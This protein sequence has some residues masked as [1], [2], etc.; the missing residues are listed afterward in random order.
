MFARAA[1]ILLALF[2]AVP[3]WSAG[4]E[5]EFLGA[6]TAELENP[7]DLKL[8]SDGKFLF[9]SDVGNNRIAVLNP[10]TLEF[11]SAF[12]ADHQSGTHDIDFDAQGRAYV[13]DTH[14]NRVTESGLSTLVASKC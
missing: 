6:S 1:A 10:K 11:I 13:A 4:L 9:V 5:A 14:N 7:H 2:W 8:S 3:A 12:G